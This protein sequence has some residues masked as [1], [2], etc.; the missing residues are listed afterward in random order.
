MIFVL[1][2][3][4]QMVHCGAVA[5]GGTNFFAPKSQNMH[6]LKLK[7][8]IHLPELWNNEISP[9]GTSR[10]KTL[11]F[12]NKMSYL[13]SLCPPSFQRLAMA[14]LCK[15]QAWEVSSEWV[16]PQTW[17]LELCAKYITLCEHTNEDVLFQWLH[18]RIWSTDSNVRSTYISN[19]WPRLFKQWIALS[20][21]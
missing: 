3:E 10:P 9:M 1:N 20:T 16:N 13:K 2:F 11:C 4:K 5:C 7:V 19:Y 15:I 8:K 18:Q 17:K 21:G 14:L 12:S 6:A